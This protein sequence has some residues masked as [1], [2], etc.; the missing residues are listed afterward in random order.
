MNNIPID[1][2]HTP[3]VFGLLPLATTEVTF[4]DTLPRVAE[5]PHHERIPAINYA[6]FPLQHPL[7]I[8][9]EERNT[10]RQENRRRP[11]GEETRRTL[12]TSY[13]EGLRRKRREK[14]AASLARLDSERRARQSERASAFRARQ[15]A[16]LRRNGHGYPNE[17]YEE[18]R[19]RQ[20]REQQREQ[21]TLD[22][23]N[24][25]IASL[26]R[27]GS[28]TLANEVVSRYHDDASMPNI[29]APRSRASRSVSGPVS[30][31]GRPRPVPRP[32]PAPSNRGATMETI[33]QLPTLVYKPKVNTEEGT[34]EPET[35]AVCLCEFEEGEQLRTLPCFHKYHACCIDRWLNQKSQCPVCRADVH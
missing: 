14:A 21:R 22:R 32:R 34:P 31:P 8:Q 27:S 35:C 19:Q 13:R 15:I 2:G 3:R 6:N 29:V 30:R 5:A 11:S 33:Q 7:R 20:R 23:A 24:T 26:R 10:G 4:I 28:H 9:W 16:R 12:E 17:R 1:H 25:V 18:M